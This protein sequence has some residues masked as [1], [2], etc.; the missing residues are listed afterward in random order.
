MNNLGIEIN[1]LFDL[2]HSLSAKYLKDF[3]FPWQVIKNIASILSAISSTLDNSFVCLKENVWVAQTAH[4]APSA[5]IVG[6]CI[7]GH[8]TEIRHGAF[9]RENVIIGDN[10]VIGNSVELKNSIIFDGCQIPHFNYVGDSILGYK[11]HLGAGV[12]I[13]NLKSNKSDVY[14]KT[15]NSSITSGLRKC[16]A[17]LGD[18]VEVGCNSVLNPGTLVG[19]NSIIYPLSNIRGVIKENVIYKSFDNVIEK[20]NTNG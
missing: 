17:F 19:R 18:F 15:N 20:R 2:N 6:P 9:I 14:I 10:V 8:N 4:I 13:S 16:G 7:V 11:A 12:I 1:Q 3:C 5:L